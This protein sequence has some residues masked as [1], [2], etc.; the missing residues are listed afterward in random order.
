M[1]DWIRKA[2]NDEVEA[3]TE[4]HDE[5]LKQFLS[6]VEKYNEKNPAKPAD[7][8]SVH[9][10]PDGVVVVAQF[11]SEGE[12]KVNMLETEGATVKSMKAGF[13]IYSLLMNHGFSSTLAK[14]KQ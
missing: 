3:F 12:W 5:S 4:R 1:I 13:R 10:D 6:D 11:N 8:M 9:C 14:E 7:T 2:C